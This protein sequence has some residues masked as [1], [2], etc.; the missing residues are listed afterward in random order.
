MKKIANKRQGFTII[1]VVLVLAIAGLIFMM[2]FI[3]LP[4]LQRSQRDTQRSNDISRVVT[5]LQNYQGSNRGAI[6]TTGT[7]VAGHTTPGSTAV[8]STT[9]KSWAY[10]Y[11]TYLIVNSGG[12]QDV[13]A[14]P[15]GEPYALWVQPCDPS[16]KKTTEVCTKGQ[17]F[18]V[19]FDNQSIGN[20][21]GES[22]IT[23][24]SGTGSTKGHSISII[25]NAT[26]QGEV[27]YYSTGARKVAVLYK[28]EGG[29]TFCVNN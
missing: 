17:R 19:T 25:T 5:A 15:D 12:S 7:Y 27:A 6:P 13:F 9:V 4:A 18:N 28:K 29:G 3:A 10:F 23:P 11:D 14:D 22:A 8:T 21:E 24:D 16:T 2:V 20:L 26:C 1:E